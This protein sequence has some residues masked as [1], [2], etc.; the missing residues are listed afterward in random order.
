MLGES[1]VIRELLGSYEIV[2]E[3]TVIARHRSVRRHQ[4]VL[5]PAHYAALLQPRAVRLSS[6]T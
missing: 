5:E 1:V 3:D 4:V 2:H 6:L